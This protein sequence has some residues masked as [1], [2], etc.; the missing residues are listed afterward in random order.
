MENLSVTATDIVIVL[1][2][3]LSAF[4]AYF[5]G[6]ARE[7]L[8]LGTWFGAGLAAYFGFRYVSPYARDFISSGAV[9]D[10][11]TGVGLFLGALVLLT[12]VNHALSKR[13]KDSALSAVDRILGFLFGAARGAL[14]VCVA[15]IAATWFWVEKDLP[16]FVT[17]ARALPVVRDGAGLIIRWLPEDVQKNIQQATK[18]AAKKSEQVMQAEQLLRNLDE[19]SGSAGDSTN[20]ASKAPPSAYTG[21]ERRELQRLINGNQ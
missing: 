3:M 16:T 18:D 10:I 11:T 13:V 6:F 2:L 5:R 4:L 14:I 20:N 21:K 19:K 9:A 7:V 15:Y 1:V 17:D 12:F 8:S